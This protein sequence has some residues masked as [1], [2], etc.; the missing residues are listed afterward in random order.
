MFPNLHAKYV[1]RRLPK[2]RCTM[3]QSLAIVAELSSEE[4]LLMKGYRHATFKESLLECQRD[5][6]EDLVN[7][8]DLRNV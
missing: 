5:K 3:G 4:M 8:A 2:N 1:Q 6:A 7:F